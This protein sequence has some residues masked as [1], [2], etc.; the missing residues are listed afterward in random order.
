MS[1]VEMICPSGTSL[2]QTTTC[3]ILL[4][5]VCSRHNSA[6]WRP[7]RHDTRHQTRHKPTNS[8]ILFSFKQIPNSTHYSKGFEIRWP[9]LSW[10]TRAWL[11]PG[12]VSGASTSTGK[13]IFCGRY[14]WLLAFTF[15]KVARDSFINAINRQRKESNKKRVSV[16]TR[17]SNDY[18]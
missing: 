2:L 8:S 4:S 10:T 1:E 12:T 18:L 13:N 5:P 11:Y 6:S 14:C 15:R 7:R 16:R 9:L 17:Y 3:F